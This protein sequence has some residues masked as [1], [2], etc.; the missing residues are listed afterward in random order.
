MLLENKYRNAGFFSIVILC[1]LTW[2]F[3]KTYIQFFPGFQGFKAVHHIHG[4]LMM[5]W[6]LLLIVQPF[7]I[8]MKRYKLHRTIGKSSYLLAPLVALSIFIVSGT[9][10]HKML[11]DQAPLPVA[12]GILALNIPG[13]FAFTTFYILAMLHKKQSDIHM[14]YMIGTALLMIGPG[15][16][17]GLITYGNIPFEA[18]VTYSDEIVL[19]ISLGLLL[20]DVFKKK[21]I[22]P[23]LTI[24][25]ALL[26]SHIFWLTKMEPVWQFLG[27]SFAKIFY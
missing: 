26:V 9:G 22:R 17:R 12:V 11:A 2:G 8:S 19:L 25:L 6:V 16:G 3:Y 24:F 7:L 14:R 10:Y 20:Y 5:L 27:G 1:V 13:A 15:L 23:Y 4:M 21:N 18:G